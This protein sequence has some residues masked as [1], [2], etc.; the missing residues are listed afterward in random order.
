MQGMYINHDGHDRRHGIIL[1]EAVLQY[2][3]LIGW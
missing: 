2:S 3:D 1:A